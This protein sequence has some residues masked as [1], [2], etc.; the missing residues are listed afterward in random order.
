[1]KKTFILI[2]LFQILFICSCS[3]SANTDYVQ[4]EANQA[5]EVKV[6]FINLENGTCTFLE[7]PGG[8]SMLIDCGSE[9]D[10]LRSLKRKLR[11]PKPQIYFSG[12]SEC[13]L[14]GGR[15]YELFVKC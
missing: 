9:A 7:L 5:D 11:Q 15:V 1:M 2:I 6:H 3:N 13:V 8:E 12:N 4:M 10:F 14:K